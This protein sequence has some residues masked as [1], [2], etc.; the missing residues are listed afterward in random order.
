MVHNLEVAGDAATHTIAALAVASGITSLAGAASMRVS[1]VQF[2]APSTNSA[3]LSRV[4]DVNTDATHG[5]PLAASSGQMLPPVTQPGIHA[6]SLT[7]LNVYVPNGDK[8]SI[9]WEA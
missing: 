7:Q 4:G 9:A 3:T 5:L 1:W 8:L 6:Y 2:I